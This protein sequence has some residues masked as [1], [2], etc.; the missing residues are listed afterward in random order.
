[1]ASQPN[2]PAPFTRCWDAAETGI[3]ESYCSRCFRLVAASRNELVLEIAER[4]HKCAAPVA[5]GHA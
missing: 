5:V 3:I 2:N 4:A 1:M